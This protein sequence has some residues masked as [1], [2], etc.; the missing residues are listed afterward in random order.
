METIQIYL[1]ELQEI[2]ERHSKITIPIISQKYRL[3]KGL[4]LKTHGRLEDRVVAHKLFQEVADERMIWPELTTEAIINLCEL[5]V[6]E[7]EFTGKNAVQHE[8]QQVADRLLSLAKSQNSFSLLVEAYLIQSKL[9]LL[10]L[11]LRE[12]QGL[13]TQA[14]LITQEK[15][16]GRL[17]QIVE[18][19]HE[20]LSGQLPIWEKIIEQKPTVSEILKLTQMETFLTQMVQKRLYRH[21][22]EVLAYAQKAHRLVKSWEERHPSS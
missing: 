7:L 14:F 5:L 16:L 4:F 13:L 9:Q 3:A 20:T 12:A 15:S 22:K 11:N 19:E 8:L 6:A 17:E 18:V 10:N 1:D 2:S 21:E